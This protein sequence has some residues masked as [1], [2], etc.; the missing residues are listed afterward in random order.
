[1]HSIEAAVLGRFYRVFSCTFQGFGGYM[2]LYARKCVHDHTARKC[3]H[4]FT[5]L[6]PRGALQEAYTVHFYVQPCLQTPASKTQDQ[7]P[8]PL[9]FRPPGHNHKVPMKHAPLAQVQQVICASPRADS[10]NSVNGKSHWM[11]TPHS[12]LNV[13]AQQRA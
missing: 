9:L 3:V 2:H 13:C 7:R 8:P 4:A 1:M 6:C 11:T 12:A 5:I 10:V